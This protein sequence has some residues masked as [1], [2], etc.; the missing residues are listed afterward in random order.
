MYWSIWPER[1]Q[2]G[3][4]KGKGKGEGEG[5]GSERQVVGGGERQEGENSRSLQARAILTFSLS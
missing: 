1:G 2:E 3:K 5:E 4:G